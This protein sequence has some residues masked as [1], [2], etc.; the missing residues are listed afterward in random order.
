METE[1]YSMNHSKAI[2]REYWFLRGHTP[3][4]FYKIQNSII[5]KRSHTYLTVVKNLRQDLFC[6]KS[7][8]KI[9]WKS[10]QFTFLSKFDDIF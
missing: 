9:L 4:C 7:W 5:A 10:N 8:A 3:K 2:F 6:G 1:F